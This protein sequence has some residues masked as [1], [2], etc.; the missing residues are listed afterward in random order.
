M[1][2]PQQEHIIKIRGKYG[3]KGL[4]G[5][6]RD[7]DKEELLKV[8]ANATQYLAEDIY[9]HRSHSECPPFGPSVGCAPA[10]TSP[11][12]PPLHAVTRMYMLRMSSQTINAMPLIHHSPTAPPP[13]RSFLR[14]HPKRR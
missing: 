1:A 4:A 8:A 7:P 6:E 2:T 10:Q 11:I 13:P 5:E 3:F 9:A 14:A 12:C